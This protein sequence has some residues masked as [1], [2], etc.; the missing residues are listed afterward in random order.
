MVPASTSLAS[1]Y[2]RFKTLTLMFPSSWKIL[3]FLPLIQ[4]YPTGLE[5]SVSGSIFLS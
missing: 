3:L 4:P 5:V 2:S 1:F